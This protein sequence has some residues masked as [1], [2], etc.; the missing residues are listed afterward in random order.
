MLDNSSQIRAT[1]GNKGF[2]PCHGNGT[3]SQCLFASSRRA[4]RTITQSVY[5]SSKAA[6]SNKTAQS[7]PGRNI[8]NDATRKKRATMRR[9]R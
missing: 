4:S 1:A 8:R 5:S 9:W 7:I 2:A 3:G 6:M